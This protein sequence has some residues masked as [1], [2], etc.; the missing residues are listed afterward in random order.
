LD[1]YDLHDLRRG[2]EEALPNGG[3]VNAPM[4]LADHNIVDVVY[5]TFE[6]AC[7]DLRAKRWADRFMTYSAVQFARQSRS[8][9]TSFTTLKIR[10]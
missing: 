7:L 4:A 6:I 8:T 3:R 1:S 10:I 9:V 5:S 2:V